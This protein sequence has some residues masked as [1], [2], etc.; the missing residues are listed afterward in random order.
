MGW[1]GALCPCPF[2][3]YPMTTLP[4]TNQP[5]VEEF[6]ED[7]KTDVI[8]LPV[9]WQE[10]LMYARRTPDDLS[11]LNFTTCT[12]NITLANLAISK[13]LKVNWLM[14]EHRQCAISELR[15]LMNHA[16]AVLNEVS[17]WEY[18]KELHWADLLSEVQ[19]MEN[20][21]L[22]SSVKFKHTPGS[23]NWQIRAVQA[24]PVVLTQPSGEDP[25]HLGRFE[26]IQSISP[27]LG[28]RL[29]ATTIDC[30]RLEIVQA[31]NRP[32][33]RSY[34]NRRYIHPHIGTSAQPCLG[35]T[36]DRLTQL[37]KDWMLADYFELI[38][39]G[40]RRYNADSPYQGLHD[41]V[42]PKRCQ[43][44]DELVDGRPHVWLRGSQDERLYALREHTSDLIRLVVNQRLTSMQ[45]D[46]RNAR[47]F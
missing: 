33:L 3:G 7:V 11:N 37:A 20:S 13:M 24:E 17:D 41:W 40:L 47:S 42:Q 9:E 26:I 10:S 28:R 29:G 31:Q 19:M 36:R 18:H 21:G 32:D 16:R 25:V 22:W 43:I 44:T 14:D 23:M 27:N 30:E 8:D 15:E 2:K 45:R 6:K 38:D 1:V 12:E 35:N 39:A 34:A 46:F 5:D 4:Q